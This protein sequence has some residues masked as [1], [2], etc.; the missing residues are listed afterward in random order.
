MQNLLKFCF[1][2]GI[3]GVNLHTLKQLHTGTKAT[4]LLFF[5]F[6]IGEIKIAGCVCLQKKRLF[7]FSLKRYF[8]GDF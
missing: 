2:S 1:E 4:H 6:K 8:F 7:T 5:Y 3:R